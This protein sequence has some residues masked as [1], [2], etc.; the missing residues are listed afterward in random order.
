MKIVHWTY[1]SDSDGDTVYPDSDYLPD[2][3]F[4]RDV[5]LL[6]VFFQI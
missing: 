1:D 4:V 3:V 5:G 6:F 2:S